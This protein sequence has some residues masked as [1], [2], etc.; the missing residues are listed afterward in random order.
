MDQYKQIGNAVPGDLGYAIAQTLINHDKGNDIQPP[1]NFPF[2]R[3]KF[4]TEKDW[5]KA[6][7]K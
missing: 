2:S 5:K 6:F 7:K 4:T 3:Y 1:E